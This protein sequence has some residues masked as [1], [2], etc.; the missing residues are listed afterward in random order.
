LRCER[1]LAI[2]LGNGEK[3][4]LHVLRFEHV[5]NQVLLRTDARS[6]D[7]NEGIPTL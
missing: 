3:A 5:F 4:G 1:L 6:E 7:K 2:I